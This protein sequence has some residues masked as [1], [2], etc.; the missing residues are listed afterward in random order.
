MTQEGEKYCRRSTTLCNCRR[1]SAIFWQTAA[2]K[3]R[4]WLDPNSLRL[5]GQVSSAIGLRLRLCLRLL[6]LRLL[7]SWG[8]SHRYL[9]S[10][11]TQLVEIGSSARFRAELHKHKFL[12]IQ[13]TNIYRDTAA[14]SSS[15]LWSL[16]KIHE[17]RGNYTLCLTIW[18]K[19]KKPTID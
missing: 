15:S 6:R 5:A 4:L 1:Y 18:N 7:L 17:L 11:N 14:V 9:A 10:R 8:L 3:L 19:K 2:A 13:L 16:C 12:L